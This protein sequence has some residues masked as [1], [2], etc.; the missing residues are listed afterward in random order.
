MCCHGIKKPKFNDVCSRMVEMHSKRPR[1][2]NYSLKTRSGQGASF[3]RLHLLQTLCHLL[4]TLL[5]TLQGAIRMTPSFFI[6]RD[7][8]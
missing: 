7:T 5:N 2:Q 1:F 6:V 3:F 4:K 8:E